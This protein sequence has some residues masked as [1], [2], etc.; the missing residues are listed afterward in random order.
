MDK[1]RLRE[2]E[3][4]NIISKSRKLVE[5]NNNDKFMNKYILEKIFNEIILLNNNKNEENKN[6]LKN[7][8]N[9]SYQIKFNGL[10]IDFDNYLQSNYL[11]SN[12]TKINIIIDGLSGIIIT[13]SQLFQIIYS[14]NNYYIINLIIFNYNNDII[15]NSLIDNN[16]YI[17]KTN[18]I[19]LLFKSMFNNNENCENYSKYW[20]DYTNIT[21]ENKDIKFKDF[22]TTH[23]LH[24]NKFN[25]NIFSNQK[26]DFVR[27]GD[28]RVIILLNYNINNINMTQHIV[29]AYSN[30]K[31]YYI[32][33]CSYIQN[34]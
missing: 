17:M 4:I 14:N 32:V 34:R 10:S 22:D 25:K 16:D 3:N 11:Q 23:Y 31:E 28:R 19:Y 21:I 8:F 12:N 33:S 30:N 26:F 6:K 18:D 9:N 1:K 15:N 27:N 7:Y 24:P 5:D 13:N 2:N 29:F 20:K